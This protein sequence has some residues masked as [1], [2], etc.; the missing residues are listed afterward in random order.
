M[1]IFRSKL[2]FSDRCPHRRCLHEYLSSVKKGTGEDDRRR[3]HSYMMIVVVHVACN[4]RNDLS[5]QL[6]NLR[7]K[8]KFLISC[9][10]VKTPQSREQEERSL[11]SAPHPPLQRQQNPPRRLKRLCGGAPCSTHVPHG[12]GRRKAL[13]VEGVLCSAV[14]DRKFIRGLQ[15]C[16]RTVWSPFSAFLV[17]ERENV[18]PQV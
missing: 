6:K 2:F 11:C 17:V 4:R 7:S 9:K 3:A 18:G 1:W 5:I 16:I 13:D 8:R 15:I 14:A 12:R 10:I